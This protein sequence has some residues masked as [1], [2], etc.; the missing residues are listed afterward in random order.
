RAAVAEPPEKGRATDA[1]LRLLADSLKRPVSAIT[2]LRG[3][4]SRQ[5]DLLVS[6]VTVSEVVTQLH[7]LL[8]CR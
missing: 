2:L 4:S 6:G 1:V 3:Q 8:D 5:K 7:R